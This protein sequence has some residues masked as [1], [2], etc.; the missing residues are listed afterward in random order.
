MGRRPRGPVV[1]L[2]AVTALALAG[3]LFAP[4]PVVRVQG[5]ETGATLLCL[6]LP[7]D[8]RVTL[9]F[10]NSLYGGEVRETYR[11]TGDGRLTRI[12]MTTERAAAAEYY[13][14]DGRVTRVA[15]GY[16]V[17]GPPVRTNALPVLLDR[18]GQHRL[19]MG[20]EEYALTT[21]DMDPIAAELRVATAPVLARWL[22]ADGD[23]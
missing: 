7:P 9:V 1:A 4:R 14:W 18:I 5:R 23:C 20:D 16:R 11:A 17:T 22:P 6:A 21:P 13:A 3:A 12:D 8:G 15:N 19:R 2:I 10:Q